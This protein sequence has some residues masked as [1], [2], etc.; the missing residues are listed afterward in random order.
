MAVAGAEA[1]RGRSRIWKT[2]VVVCEQSRLR[3]NNV[4]YPNGKDG[5]INRAWKQSALVIFMLQCTGCMDQMRRKYVLRWTYLIWH[6]CSCA[7]SRLQDPADVPFPRL[8]ACIFRNN[9]YLSLRL[10]T[11][12]MCIMQ[13]TLSITLTSWAVP[14]ACNQNEFDAQLI[15]MWPRLKNS[16]LGGEPAGPDLPLFRPLLLTPGKA[17][18]WL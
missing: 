12:R 2:V 9:L 8:S 17:E 11:R 5:A 15:A 10:R 16:S 13:K 14:V 18:G 4:P 3:N 7:E 6:D 1:W